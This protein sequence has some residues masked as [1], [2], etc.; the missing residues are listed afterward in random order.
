[1]TPKQEAFVREYL[2]DLNATQAAIRAGYSEKTANEQGS[3]LL[4]DVSV[5]S[6]IEAAKAARSERT[7]INAD[8][9]LRTLAEEKTADLADLY[10]EHGAMKP[11]KDWPLAFRRGVVVGVETVEEFVGVGEDRKPIQ[12][13][14][15]KMTD[16]TKHIE[17]IGKHVRVQAFRDNVGISD[18]N[19]K[20]LQTTLDVSALSGAALA[21]LLAA[22][23]KAASAASATD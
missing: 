23:D 6:A 2:I 4:A 9:V 7:E 20:P 10:D 1:M 14:K 22:R 12:I 11:I 16:R 18:P 3:R 13:R 21:E 5:R 8:W 15:I 19:G 17:L